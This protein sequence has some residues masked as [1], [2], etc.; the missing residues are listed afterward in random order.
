MFARADADGDG[1][2][3]TLDIYNVLCEY[4]EAGEEE[5]LQILCDPDD[6]DLEHEE[7]IERDM[8]LGA[9]MAVSHPHLREWVIV[10]TQRAADAAEAL[11]P[12]RIHP[13]AVVP[14]GHGSA[15]AP[16]ARSVSSAP[17]AAAPRRAMRG[18]RTSAAGRGAAAAAGAVQGAVNSGDLSAYDAENAELSAALERALVHIKTLE[19]ELDQKTTALSRSESE[20]RVVGGELTALKT[21]Q[22]R[23]RRIALVAGTHGCLFVEILQGRGL[24]PVDV[25]TTDP[26]VIVVRQGEEAGRTGTVSNTCDPRWDASFMFRTDLAAEIELNI[27]DFDHLGNH[28]PMGAVKVLM[29]DWVDVNKR[30]DTREGWLTLEDFDGAK[31]CSGEVYARLTFFRR[32]TDAGGESLD[33]PGPVRGMLAVEVVEARD[34][35]PMDV[36]GTISAFATINRFDSKFGQTSVKTREMNPRWCHRVEF[37]VSTESFSEVSIVVMHKEPH[38]SKRAAFVALNVR[39]LLHNV[40]D[41]HCNGE[42][43]YDLVVERDRPSPTRFFHDAPGSGMVAAA[44]DS[45]RDSERRT[46]AIMLKWSFSPIVGR[47]G[48]ENFYC[49][50]WLKKKK[51]IPGDNTFQARYYTMHG[52]AIRYYSS[53]AKAH[54][55]LADLADSADAGNATAGKHTPFIL[56]TL[57]EVR[58]PSEHKFLARGGTGFDLI[59]LDRVF[60]FTHNDTRDSQLFCMMMFG[61][62]PT[63]SKTLRDASGSDLFVLKCSKCGKFVGIRAKQKKAVRK[64]KC[65]NCGQVLLTADAMNQSEMR[66]RFGGAEQEE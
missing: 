3:K 36:N 12:P 9:M 59:F 49:T 7:P 30:F 35:P 31:K 25:G 14:S 54:K 34:L 4:A 42:G 65:S 60:N 8:F 62:K 47:L 61:L 10:A 48:D 13:R 50:G 55:V 29:A 44:R 15:R 26:Y 43:W 52:E 22:E 41:T 24:A 6:P 57:R 5:V 39:E 17:A 1:H 33:I 56:D 66:E 53:I 18:A 32:S 23:E 40:V 38:A 2:A 27:R 46:P 28:A 63:K 37:D 58:F 21:A 51:N 20:L 16:V 45:K 64:V 11:Q 19:A